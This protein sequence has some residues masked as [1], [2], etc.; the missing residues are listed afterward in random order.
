[1]SIDRNA[2]W[3]AIQGIV[4]MVWHRSDLIERWIWLMHQETIGSM[5]IGPSIPFGDLLMAELVISSMMLAYRA[6]SNRY[7]VRSRIE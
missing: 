7:D 4:P 2:L 3:T 5:M 6:M 1:M